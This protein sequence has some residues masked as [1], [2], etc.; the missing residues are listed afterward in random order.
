[1]TFGKTARDAVISA[2]KTTQSVDAISY[3]ITIFP[4]AEKS[5]LS[6]LISEISLSYKWIVDEQIEEEVI[7]TS[8]KKHYM[9][10]LSL[11][12]F[13]EEDDT[14]ALEKKAD[15]LLV[16]IIEDLWKD[17]PSVLATYDAK[18]HLVG[19]ITDLSYV[20]GFKEI[21]HFHFDIHIWYEE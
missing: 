10:I 4:D 1:M 6:N 18:L 11:H 2:I 19:P 14:F 15:Q 16:A 7:G 3:S 13:L 12:L 5:Q 17:L 8:F 21:G 9:A 20:R